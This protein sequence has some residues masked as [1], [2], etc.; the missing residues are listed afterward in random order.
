M[1]LR[2]PRSEFVRKALLALAPAVLLLATASSAS[3]STKQETI[4]QDDRLFGTP[5]TQVQAL[6]DAKALGVDTVH[7]VITFRSLA[8]NADS[9]NKP[10]GF[11]AADPGDYPAES[12][13]R[14]DSLVREASS[15]RIDLLFSP[16]TP[17]P[18]WAAAARAVAT[19]PRGSA[20]PMTTSTRTSSLP[21]SSATAAATATRTR[22]AG[23][24]RRSIASRSRTSRT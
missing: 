5:G 18:D 10:G 16:A 9:E 8:P 4:L 17:M 2:S 22:A 21:S 3:A 1:T 24:C 19:P 14:F 7:S 11:D 6:D 23:D 13:D 12:W 15:R 20:S